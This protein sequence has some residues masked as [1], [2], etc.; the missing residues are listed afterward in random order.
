MVW[1][2]KIKTLEKLF[3]IFLMI[4]IDCQLRTLVKD[5]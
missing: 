5:F 2:I 4:K 3:M 1:L